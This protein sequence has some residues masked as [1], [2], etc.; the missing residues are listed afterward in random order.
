MLRA[1]RPRSRIKII[2][3]FNYEVKNKEYK[4]LASRVPGTLKF[5]FIKK[6][7]NYI[8]FSPILVSK[9]ALKSSN[10]GLKNI[11]FR[12]II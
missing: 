11:L 7:N 5:Y 4:I 3:I 1:L 9:I 6:N 12:K 8:S 10:L 2:L